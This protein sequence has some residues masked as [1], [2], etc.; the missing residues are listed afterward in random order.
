ML[1]VKESLTIEFK[2]EQKR[3]QSHDETADNVA[4]PANTEGGTLY[5]GIEGDDTVIGVCDEYRNINEPAALVL[6]RTIPQ[7]PVRVALLY[8][9][10]V[11][12]ASIETDNNRQI[13]S[14]SQGKV[15]QHRPEA[16]GLSEAALL[17]VS[18]F[19]GRLP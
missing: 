4:A 11:P 14:T 9:S 13:I 1:P 7:L 17:F 12:I 8:E 19:I 10:K 5:L 15:L 3:P 16:D 2:S 6:N 18:Q